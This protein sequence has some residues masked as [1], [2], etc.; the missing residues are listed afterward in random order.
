[1]SGV[2]TQGIGSILGQSIDQL[3]KDRV[4]QQQITRAQAILQIALRERNRRESLESSVREKEVL[5]RCRKDFTRTM[6]QQA[7]REFV[8]MVVDQISKKSTEV[9]AQK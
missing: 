7:H 1:M 2:V 6:I 5:D 4:R 8:N 9:D 3:E